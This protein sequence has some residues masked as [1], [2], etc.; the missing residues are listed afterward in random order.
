M[1]DAIA[2]AMS[3]MENLVRR[4]LSQNDFPL[5]LAIVRR[6]SRPLAALTMAIV[7]SSFVTA[8]VNR[9][10]RLIFAQRGT[11]PLLTRVC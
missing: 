10:D 9:P 3:I 5:K 4:P 11:G 1:L 2:K 8:S 6:G 7:C